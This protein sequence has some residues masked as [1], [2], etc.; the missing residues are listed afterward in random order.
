MAFQEEILGACSE[1]N[2]NLKITEGNNVMILWGIIQT[3]SSGVKKIKDCFILIKK[4][5]KEYN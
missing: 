3:L 4:V 5:P 1:A 2:I